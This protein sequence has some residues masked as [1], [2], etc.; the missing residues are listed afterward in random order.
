[1]SIFQD[2]SLTTDGYHCGEGA[3]QD[4]NSWTSIVYINFNGFGWQVFGFLFLEKL[5]SMRDLCS[6][7]SLCIFKLDNSKNT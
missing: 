3:A 4:S 7:C 1:M 2:L 5:I 6:F